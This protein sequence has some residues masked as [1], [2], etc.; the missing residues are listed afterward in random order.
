MPNDMSLPLVLRRPPWFLMAVSLTAQLAC[1]SFERPEVHIEDHELDWVE[2][3]RISTFSAGRALDRGLVAEVVEYLEALP[4]EQLETP[5]LLEVYGKGLLA[6]GRS[7]EALNAFQRGQELT[8]S[9]TER[10]ARLAWLESQA[11]F[12]LGDPGRA[13]GPAALA[14]SRMKDLKVPSGWVAYLEKMKADGTRL[15]LIGE[16]RVHRAL[17]MNRIRV[18]QIKIEVNGRPLGAVIDTGASLT[19]ISQRAAKKANVEPFEGTEAE[20]SG[21]H[22]RVFPVEYGVIDKLDLGG[23]E[24]FNVAVGVVPDWV[25]EFETEWGLVRFDIL[26]GTHLWKDLSLEIDYPA[27][28][29]TITPRSQAEDRAAPLSRNLYLA[30]GKPLVRGSLNGSAPFRYLLDTGSEFTLVHQAGYSRYGRHLPEQRIRPVTVHGLGQ[31]QFH[32]RKVPDVKVGVGDFQVVFQHLLLTNQKETD[33]DG[34]I[35]TTFLEGFRV[36]FDFQQHELKL[37]HVKP[38]A[39]GPE[40]P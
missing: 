1:S 27:K 38:E 30:D 9:S 33:D 12:Q 11:A 23:L 8:S 32:W 24:I 25:V 19:F 28:T 7:A 13:A 2:P 39:N 22:G 6:M 16:G 18:P 36:L 34:I 4:A 3:V 14:A 17:E 35:G 21:L 31:A 5:K 29:V 20:G 40:S 15:N 26:L 37:W 10:G